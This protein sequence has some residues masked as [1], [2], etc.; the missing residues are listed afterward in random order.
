MAV[1]T[2]CDISAKNSTFFLETDRYHVCVC[3]RNEF[4]Q[5]GISTFSGVAYV[6]TP[7]RISY[8]SI[9]GIAKIYPSEH[10]TFFLL[11]NGKA[12]GV[13]NNEY[14]Q[15][16]VNSLELRID[17]PLVVTLSTNIE[18]ISFA[19]CYS[20]FKLVNGTY[21][22]AGASPTESKKRNIPVVESN[23][24]T[25]LV[26]DQDSFIVLE[27]DYP[28]KVKTMGANLY[29]E[30][31]TMSMNSKSSLT[32]IP[33]YS[34]MDNIVKVVAGGE[35]VLYLTK[36]GNVYAAGSND[37]YQLGFISLT[38]T[39]ST[40]SIV[41]VSNI[42][43]IAAGYDHSLFLDNKG[44]LYGCGSNGYGQLGLGA[45]EYI[46]NPTKIASN[47]LTMRC[48]DFYTFVID[49]D[50]YI[51]ATGYNHDGQLGIANNT[52]NRNTL[53][54][55]SLFKFDITLDQVGLPDD[56]D[57]ECTV[58]DIYHLIQIVFSNVGSGT[59]K[60]ESYI[61]TPSYSSTTT[62]ERKK[63]GTD[64]LL[65]FNASTE[66]T[67][68]ETCLNRANTRIR[69]LKDY[70][71]NK[72]IYHR[73][74]IYSTKTMIYFNDGSYIEREGELLEIEAKLQAQQ[75]LLNKYHVD[76]QLEYYSDSTFDNVKTVGEPT[77]TPSKGGKRIIISEIDTGVYNYY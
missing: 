76:T 3:G 73:E 29:G 67:V 44:N 58:G 38:T 35:H 34:G 39:V 75:Y 19:G 53:T 68:K 13:G 47:V 77:W 43:D 20:L 64:I 56:I 17:N 18:D 61:Y 6:K 52:T 51:Y 65:S 4:N 59:V 45:K 23:L 25:L 14:G 26:N 27:G 31:S 62:D 28:I 7:T 71:N 12:Y 69:E 49:K 5:L 57:V 33:E 46:Q 30:L 55:L 24:G 36:E 9:T 72:T 70:I 60:I 40:P 22:I 10:H 42:V 2:V 21:A 48:G 37:K 11:D 66:D 54:K 50:G 15:L 41:N 63:V 8:P 32:Y 1:T 74:P 16:G